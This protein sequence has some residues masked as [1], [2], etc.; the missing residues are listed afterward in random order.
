[1]KESAVLSAMG[2]PREIAD[3]FLRVSF[4]PYTSEADI[5]RFLAE[6]RRIAERTAARAA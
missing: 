5:D 3:G 2:V 1:M 4:G 6:W